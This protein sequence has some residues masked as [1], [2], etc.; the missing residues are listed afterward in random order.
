MIAK[1]AKIHASAII[2]KGAI[3]KE[4]AFI[5]PFCYIGANVKV[6][7]GTI[8]RSHVVINGH[9]NIG[10][11]NYIYQF[12][13]IGEA[14]QDLK[15]SNEPMRVEIGDNNQIRESVTIH[16][17]TLKGGGITKIGSNSLF[18]I[19]VHIAHDCI[20][21]N[22][23]IF[24][25]NVILGGH[26]TVDNFVVI[27]GLTAIHQWCTI[28][29]HVMIGGCSGIVKDIPPYILAQGNHATPFGINS[30]GLRKRGFSNESLYAIYT[31]YKLL[32]RSGK[33]LNEVKPKIK[34]LAEKFN[35]IQPFYNFFD[36]ST[37]GVIR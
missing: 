26:V 4:N 24:A 37:R 35:E 8:L 21:G 13:S 9:T 32:Y 6:G 10:K 18:M 1:T 12:S 7:E 25:N 11:N 33:K 31:A 29:T 19:N 17:G 3:I 5:G 28:G 34:D 14:N 27:G 22:N 36:R 16:R 30:K 15:Y 23:C 2:E 20:I